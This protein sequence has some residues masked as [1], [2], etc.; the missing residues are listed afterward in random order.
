MLIAGLLCPGNE[1]GECIMATWHRIPVPDVLASLEYLA[2]DDLHAVIARAQGLLLDRPAPLG[3][4]LDLAVEVVGH[5][6]SRL[7]AA[8]RALAPLAQ[9][10]LVGRVVH[11]VRAPR[12]LSRRQ[13]PPATAGLS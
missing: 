12:R 13:R 5:E 6:E 10:R 1:R 8:Y 4:R 11:L 2:D 7:L 9:R 3:D